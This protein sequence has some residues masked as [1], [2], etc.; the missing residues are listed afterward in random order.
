[1]QQFVVPQFID[2][3]DK[4]LG[5]LT[6]RQFVILLVAAIIDF[7]LYKLLVFI[8]F[9]IFGLAVIALA[10]VLA[11]VK[12]NGQPFHY[13]LLNLL[14][15]ARRPKLKIWDKE[16]T[17]EELKRYLKPEEVKVVV[18][19]PTKEPLVGTKLAELALIVDTGGA[20]KGE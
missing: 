14:Q 2:V 1:M 7:I 12:I 8:Y 17:T 9:V 15:T 19:R 20:Y 18:P 16:L 6:T 10:G 13:F 3:E 5:P 11:F 4:I